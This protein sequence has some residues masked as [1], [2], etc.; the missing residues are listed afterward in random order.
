MQDTLAFGLR[1]IDIITVAAIVLGPILAVLVDKIRQ[2]W[3]DHKSRK[4]SVFRSLMRTRRVRLDPEHVGAL[5][6]VDLEFY[7]RSRVIAAFSSYMNHLSSPMPSEEGQDRFFEQRDDLLVQLLYEMGRDLGFHYDKRDLAK[8][9]YGPTGWFNEQD[10][11][12]QNMG[13]L[14]DILAGRRALPVTPMQPPAANPF[15]PAPTLGG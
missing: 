12:R 6:L 5:N 1:W 15:P 13:C 14:N 2:S 9:A 11:Q 4:L 3:T 10:L 7:G 8:H